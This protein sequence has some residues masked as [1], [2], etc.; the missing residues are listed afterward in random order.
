[1]I[2]E[3]KGREDSLRIMKINVYK[4]DYLWKKC[5]EEGLNLLTLMPRLKRRE[6]DVWNN[7]QK[8]NFTGMQHLKFHFTKRKKESFGVYLLEKVTRKMPKKY[9]QCLQKKR[10][11][12]P[13]KGSLRVTE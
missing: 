5:S 1:M 12:K 4:W 8:L 10:D 9:R 13:L 2:R 6:E 11:T 3:E 7:Y